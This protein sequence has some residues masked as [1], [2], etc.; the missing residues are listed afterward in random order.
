MP[1]RT[2]SSFKEMM[3]KSLPKRSVL[4]VFNWARRASAVASREPGPPGRLANPTSTRLRGSISMSPFAQSS[5]LAAHDPS[6]SGFPVSTV[7]REERMVSTVKRTRLP[8]A[9]VIVFSVVSEP[10]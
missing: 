1:R 7:S 3:S 2:V 10:G 5:G 9:V 4:P 6:Y 8:L